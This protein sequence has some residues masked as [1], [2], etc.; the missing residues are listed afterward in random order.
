MDAGPGGVGVGRADAGAGASFLCASEGVSADGAQLRWEVDKAK[1]KLLLEVDMPYVTPANVDVRY[2]PNE[3]VVCTLQSRPGPHTPSQEQAHRRGL[4][5]PQQAGAARGLLL[6]RARG[7]HLP[8]RAHAARGRG[9]QGAWPRRAGPGPA[10]RPQEV[11]KMTAKLTNGTLKLA[12][13]APPSILQEAEESGQE[14]G[15][16]RIPVTQV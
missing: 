13:K 10:D 2:L 7:R 12:M 3:C 14:E 11:K 15:V 5:R 9:R 6:R 8:P 4:V 16:S 1:G